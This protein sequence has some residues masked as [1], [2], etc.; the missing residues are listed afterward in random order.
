[1]PVYLDHNATTP[2]D[3]QVLEAMLPY[4]GEHFGNPSSVHRFGRAAR[5]AVERAR[6]QVAQLVQAHPSQVIF[7]SGGTEA[8]NLA[9]K[10]AAA[11]CAPGLIAVGATEH[12]SVAEAAGALRRQGWRVATI[13]VDTQGRIG[14]EVIE[15]TLRQRPALVCAMLA[16]NETGVIQDIA[17]L[18]E[19]ARASGAI[20]HTDAVQAAGKIE[21]NFTDSG[22]QSMSLSAHKINGPKGAGALIVEKSVEIEPLLHGGGQEKNRRSGT[23]NVAG[24][25]GFGA[26]AAAARARLAVYGA[27]MS[28]LRARLESGLDTIGGIE[29]FAAGAPRLPNTVCFAAA[30]VDGEALVLHLDK[31]G[32]AVSSGAACASGT[33]EP[34]P[35]LTAMGVAAELARGAL[36]ASLGAGNTEEDIDIFIRA[37]AAQLPRLRGFA[38]AASA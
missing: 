35:V 12:P 27:R 26:A 4:L 10:G 18:A 19:A 6:A 3:P 32:V 15:A 2:M 5:A 24:I 8:N 11:L 31:A 14:P 7:T 28:A 34:S 36:R 9:I 23:E 17:R 16:N 29:V 30:G 20:L 13:P 38:R 33:A 37:L 25:V 21:V 1:M 22:A